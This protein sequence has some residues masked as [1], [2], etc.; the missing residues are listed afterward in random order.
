MTNFDKKEL[1][2]LIGFETEKIEFNLPLE[3]K[4]LKRH[5]TSFRNGKMFNYDPSTK[6]KN[7]IKLLSAQYMPD[8]PFE[9]EIYLYI[10]F[11][12]KR[13]KSHYGTGKNS[14]IIKSS[15]PETHIKKPDLSNMI[16]LIE[17]SFNGMFYK[18]DS[19]ITHLTAVKEYTDIDPFI[20]ICI[21]N[22]KNFN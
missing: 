16:K 15:A 13:P 9:N 10:K 19:Q 17:D 3:P 22:R 8:E 11:Y 2:K 1:E 4:A 6:D 12:M 14:N 20:Y 5:R 18:D 21:V 7:K